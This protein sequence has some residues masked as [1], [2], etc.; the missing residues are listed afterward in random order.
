MELTRRQLRKALKGDEVAL[1]RLVDLLT[2]VIQARVARKLLARAG[3]AA[4]RSIR[5]EVEDLTQEVFLALFDNDAKTLRAWDPDKGL[6]LKNFVGLVADRQAVS[7][8]RTGKR[9]PWTE[10][11]TL[12]EELDLKS[13]G[14]RAEPPGPEHL[15]A[16]REALATTLERLAE[17]TSPLGQT[18]FGLLFV[19][20]LT[21]PEITR[22]M[23]MTPEAVYAW[24][25]RLSR[26]AHR[27][28]EEVVSETAPAARNPEEAGTR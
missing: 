2:P 10:E 21:V 4:G 11:P 7:I 22:R 17:Q 23:R 24:R 9:S 3:Q 13:S 8:L 28:F 26:L 6:S 15:V 5:Q 20:E 1:D 14:E 25:S 18:L 27:I 16:S 12:D 19:E